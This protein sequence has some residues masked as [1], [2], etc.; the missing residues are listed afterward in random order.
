VLGNLGL[1]ATS[2]VV[3]LLPAQDAPAPA[4]GEEF[5][6]ASPI[7]LVVIIVL[8][9]V[10]ALLIRNMSKRIKRL[11]ESFDEPE[12]KTDPENDSA[13]DDEGARS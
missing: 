2:V 12:Q 13:K 3:A 7:A 1:A 9:I 4:Q 5:G 8:A 11:P 6:E 10:T